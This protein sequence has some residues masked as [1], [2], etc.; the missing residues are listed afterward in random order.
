MTRIASEDTNTDQT[1][2]LK[3]HKG[4]NTSNR[5]EDMNTRSFSEDN[6][7]NNIKVNSIINGNSLV[8]FDN[9]FYVN[10]FLYL[11]H[12]YHCCIVQ[13]DKFVEK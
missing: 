8:I 12:F 10:L 11:F 6:K 9:V 13:L 5:M 3:I 1:V 7:L 2:N 4:V